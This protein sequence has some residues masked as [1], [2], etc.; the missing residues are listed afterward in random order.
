[1]YTFFYRAASAYYIIAMLEHCTATQ[2]QSESE[3]AA[4]A[5][6]THKETE[7]SS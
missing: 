6:R 1:M 3:K 5:E 7:V 4:E 2:Q